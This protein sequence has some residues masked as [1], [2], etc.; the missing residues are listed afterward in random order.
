MAATTLLEYMLEVNARCWKCGRV[1]ERPQQYRIIFRYGGAYGARLWYKE[2][3]Y[4]C[5]AEKPNA[6]SNSDVAKE[7]PA[8]D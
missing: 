8:H 6:P 2:C 5:V 7:Q 3:R 4:K 1:F